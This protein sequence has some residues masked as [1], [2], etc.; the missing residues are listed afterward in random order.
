MLVILFWAVSRAYAH[1]SHV[2][3]ELCFWPWKNASCPANN[4]VSAPVEALNKQINTF[5]R[6]TIK[7]LYCLLYIIILFVVFLYSILFYIYAKPSAKS[8]YVGK[9]TWKT[10]I[11]EENR[12]FFKLTINI[13]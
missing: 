7:R 6:S 8:S 11:P 1:T 3:P 2:I 4:D 13:A 9:E 10:K 12:T 5:Q